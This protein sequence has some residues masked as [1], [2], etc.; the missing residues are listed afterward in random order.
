MRPIHLGITNFQ[1]HRDLDLDFSPINLAV[2]SGPNGAGKSSIVDAI[3]FALF[4]YARGGTLDSVVTEGEQVCRVELEF[5]LG[6]ETYLV[7][8]QR[9]RRG[10]GSTALSFQR[11]RGDGWEILDGKSVAE[12]QARIEGVLHM[13]DEL[14]TATACANQ[15]NAA[16]FTR[17]R[18]A[19]RKA[20]LAEIL[21]L[22]Q[23]ERR[24]EA[25]RAML[26]DLNARLTSLRERHEA[27]SET[28][29]QV[30]EL[31]RQLEANGAAQAHVRAE[32][33]RL[34]Q[35]LAAAH[36]AK[37]KLLAAQQAAAAQRRELD[38]LT[39]QLDKMKKDIVLVETVAADMAR[40]AARRAEIA[41]AISQAEAA[42]T[43]AQE[44][45]AKRQERERIE[46]EART[47]A[48][49]IRAARAEH[50]VKVRELETR[51]ASSK[52]GWEH[53][54]DS[55]L[56]RI[57]AA[58]R[59]AEVL[60]EVP[61]AAAGNTPLVDACPLIAQAR[62]ARESLPRLEHELSELQQQQPWAEHEKQLAELRAQTPAVDLV[63]KKAKL[64]QRFD[65]IS[66]DAEA[67]A[68]AKQIA[69]RLASL[70]DELHV[71]EVSE[72]KRAEMEASL[73]KA[74]AEASRLRERKASLEAELGP[75][76][77]WTAEIAGAEKRIAATE[78]SLSEQRRRESDLAA[79]RGQLEERLRAA[80]QAAEE[81]EKVAG[82][83]AESERRSKL[84]DLLGNARTGAFSKAGIPALLIEQ[85]V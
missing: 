18:P 33:E 4:G 11:N 76:R 70:R 23:W 9:S 65:A 32:I 7:S 67:H 14:F 53:D 71:A 77:D 29:G 31:R 20:V 44:W 83:I 74:R 80:E 13:T 73:E 61:C 10:G 51:I 50:E 66:Y 75:A 28:A 19:D 54:R 37:A 45:E 64:K 24:A 30:D 12:T 3:R 49:Q 82:E 5:A 34:E 69:G 40:D 68:K 8:R 36:D 85:A 21:D 16:A 46:G 58:Q 55:L 38:E 1:S 81:A 60:D 52:R 78:K 39:A 27:L 41:D 15:G 48:E 6:D 56:S 35:E 84:L 2:L 57:E 62:D 17:A 25:A 22:G 72:A 43:E 47:L 26:R 79:Q 63:A 42:Q 59:Q